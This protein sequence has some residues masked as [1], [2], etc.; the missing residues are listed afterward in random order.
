WF[1][2]GFFRLCV[3]PLD[4][5]L[6][7]FVCILYSASLSRR[8]FS[9]SRPSSRTRHSKNGR[10]A[11]AHAD[12]FF[13]LCGRHDGAQR[14]AVLFLRG[15]DQGRNSPRDFKLAAVAFAALLGADRRDPDRAL[16]DAADHLRLFWK[17]ARC[18]GARTRKSE[19]NG[20]SSYC[21]R[22]LRSF[23]KR[24]PHAGL[25]LARK[26]FNGAS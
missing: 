24:R 13:N 9:Y 1:G 4:G 20:D 3:C 19:R 6:L 10:L 5:Y 17:P 26:L 8:W 7:A 22:S 12:Y 18:L 11:Q 21:A 23:F 16:H 2:S 15:L 14:R 25:A